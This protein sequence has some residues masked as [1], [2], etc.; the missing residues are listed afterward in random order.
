[1]NIVNSSY[2]FHEKKYLTFLNKSINECAIQNW[3]RS[4]P[5]H[6]CFSGNYQE[7]LLLPL[8]HSRFPNVLPEESVFVLD[9]AMI[10]FDCGDTPGVLGTCYLTSIYLHMSQVNPIGAQHLSL[11]VKHHVQ[12]VKVVSDKSLMDLAE[13][14]YIW[15]CQKCPHHE[16]AERYFVGLGGLLLKADRSDLDTNEMEQQ[17]GLLPGWVNGPLETYLLTSEENFPQSWEPL[18]GT[19]KYGYRLRELVGLRD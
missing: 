5:D 7:T 1:M 8:R 6:S 18:L 19:I 14:F 2:S 15:L 16:D 12:S 11:A 3:I 17:I 4:Q 13:D 9:N 10:A